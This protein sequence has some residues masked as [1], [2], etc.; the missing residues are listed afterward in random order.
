MVFLLGDYLQPNLSFLL[1]L[2]NDNKFSF[3]AAINMP[4]SPQ[5]K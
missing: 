3:S 2:G 4:L 5:I 1:L